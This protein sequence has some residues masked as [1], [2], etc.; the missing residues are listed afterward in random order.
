MNFDLI[1]IYTYIHI[2]IHIQYIYIHTHIHT[3]TIYIY[4]S[5]K[6]IRVFYF[7][8]QGLVRIAL[9][10]NENSLVRCRS[11]MAP[12]GN[13]QAMAAIAMFNFQAREETFADEHRV[14]SL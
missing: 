10:K 12:E 2:Y 7:E 8:A 9:W 11:D 6:T 1:Y 5:F 3:H 13:K 14:W 4:L